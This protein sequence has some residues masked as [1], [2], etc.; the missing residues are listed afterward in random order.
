M[1]RKKS[2]GK[3]CCTDS[4]VR[5]FVGLSAI[6]IILIILIAWGG[7]KYLG[8]KTN[9]KLFSGVPQTPDVTANWATYYGENT[10][11]TVRVPAD[12]APEEEEEE[13]EN[14]MKVTFSKQIQADVQTPTLS[15]TLFDNPQ[16]ISE[17]D[18]LNS[19]E[20][21][22]AIDKTAAAFQLEI[23]ENRGIAY[24]Q[25]SGK[26]VLTS[27]AFDTGA[28]YYVLK[29]NGRLVFIE[30]VGEKE[31]IEGVIKTLHVSNAN[32]NQ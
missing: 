14:L 29:R 24:T 26:T 23:G 1:P 15:I 10:G 12:Y 28:N 18:W 9:L 5:Q 7:S 30:C 31:I 4:H 27:E 19:A 6:I 21:L 20:G 11:L 2:K 22:K 16:N 32:N 25:I 17:V 13:D 3:K 8:D